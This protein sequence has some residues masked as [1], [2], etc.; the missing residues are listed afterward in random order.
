[1]KKSPAPLGALPPIAPDALDKLARFYGTDLDKLKITLGTAALSPERVVIGVLDCL[2]TVNGTV[3]HWC[4][5]YGKESASHFWAEP[6]PG[7]GDFDHR[8]AHH[9]ERRLS[10]RRRP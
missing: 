7:M 9:P 4:E 5:G 6:R 2:L 8:C 1:M 10:E 3:L